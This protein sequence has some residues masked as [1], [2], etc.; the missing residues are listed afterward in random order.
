MKLLMSQS[1]SLEVEAAVS[2][3]EDANTQLVSQSKS[4][5]VDVAD[6]LIEDTNTQPME[7]RENEVADS[8]TED[9]N[10]QTKPEELLN[11]CITT[12]KGKLSFCTRKQNELK[13]VV[14]DGSVAAIDKDIQDLMDALDELDNAHVLI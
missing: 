1:V 2:P 12:Q 14:Q 11:Q 6:A 9:A 3:T 10:V 8:P 4:G 5:E 7:S 13:R